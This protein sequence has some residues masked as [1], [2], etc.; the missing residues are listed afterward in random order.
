MAWCPAAAHAHRR[1]RVDDVCVCT[2][3]CTSRPR[4]R[5]RR[6]ASSRELSSPRI[7]TPPSPPRCTRAASRPRIRSSRTRSAPARRTSG[8]PDMVADRPRLGLGCTSSRLIAH[9]CA[10]SRSIAG[11]LRRGQPEGRRDRRLDGEPVE[12]GLLSRRPRRPALRGYVQ[13]WAPIASDCFEWLA[14]A[15]SGKPGVASDCSSW[16][17]CPFAMQASRASVPFS[18]TC[19][20]RAGCASSSRRTWASTAGDCRRACLQ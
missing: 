8:L 20:T 15:Q 7:L 5:L 12:G 16:S 1:A 13:I 11:L 9:D 14:R 17:A 2:A 10:S 19:L 6:S 18:T 3:P 4:R